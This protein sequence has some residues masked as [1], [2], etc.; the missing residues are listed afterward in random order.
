[1][2]V[3]FVSQMI[4]T[5]SMLGAVSMGFFGFLVFG[6]TLAIIG[7]VNLAVLVVTLVLIYFWCQPGDPGSNA[8]GPPPPVFD[9]SRR[10]SPSP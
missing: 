7:L 6:P 8:Y 9:P 2:L 4:A 5:V 10:V 1:M 3:A